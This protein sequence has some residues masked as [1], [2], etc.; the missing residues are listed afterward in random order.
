MCHLRRRKNC[1]VIGD[2][3]VVDEP[4]KAEG[5]CRRGRGEL[6][7]V[8]RFDRPDDR[9]QRRRDAAREVS[10]VGARVAEELLLLVEGLGDVERA[11]RAHAVEAVGVALELG[12]VVEP[13]RWQALGLALHRLDAR[14]TALHAGDDLLCLFATWWKPRGN[15]FTRIR[16]ADIDAAVL[17]ARRRRTDVG[18]KLCHNLQILFGHERAD[19]ELARDDEGERRGLHPPDRERLVVGDAVRAREIHPD[20]PIGAAAS[21]CGPRERVIR[22]AVFQVSESA[23]DGIGRER[24]E[25]EAPDGPLAPGGLVDVPENELSLAPRVGRADDVLDVGRVQEGADDLEL[26]TRR[27][28]DDERPPAGDDGEIGEGAIASSARRCREAPR[29]RR[30]ARWP[31]SRRSRRRE[32]TRPRVPC[33]QGRARGRARRRVFRRRRRS[34]CRSG[35]CHGGAGR[36][37]GVLNG[38]RTRSAKARQAESLRFAGDGGVPD[39]FGG[40]P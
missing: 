18:A 5:C 40:G 21:P 6:G 31:T 37:S 2:G 22:R 13:R 11:L 8:R 12:E 38:H 4:R 39:R 29:G 36:D 26:A 9:G 25:P 14:G 17:V 27:L 7:A 3:V 1:V 35:S 28:E 24:R 33:T 15:P 19:L 16:G 10:A 32:C 34:S 30:G 23:G 20:E